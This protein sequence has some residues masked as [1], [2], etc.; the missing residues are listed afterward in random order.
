MF[1]SRDALLAIAAL[2]C[3]GWVSAQ[4]ANPYT[5]IGRLATP[6]EVAA[7]DIDVRPDFKGLPAGAGSV[8]KGQDVWEGKCASCHGI[9]GESNEVFSP[10]IGGTTAED[11]K[12][13]R[14]AK[15]LDPTTG[16]TMLMKLATVSTLW[17]YINRAMPWNQPKSLTTE[18]VYAVTAFLLNLGGVIPDDYTLSDKNIADVQARMPNRNGMTTRHA[19]WPGNEFNGTRQPDVRNTACMKNCATEPRVAS[20]LPDFARNAHGNLAEQNRVIGAQ[21]G[22]DTSRPEGQKGVV[23]AVTISPA[24]A[25]SSALTLAQKNNCTACHAVDKKILGPSFVEIAKKHAGKVDYLVGKIKSGG[26]GVWGSIPMP[27]QTV[28]DADAKTIAAWLAAGAGR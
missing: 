5:G 7:W 26:V 1:N 20:L 6:K 16:R 24:T 13:G 10:L 18:E 14:A 2:V 27:A 8:A 11:V 15:L 19:M 4:T 23:A 28:S 3:A 9:F 21:H 25:V 17:D 22:V 12:T